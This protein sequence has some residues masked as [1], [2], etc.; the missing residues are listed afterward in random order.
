ML[1]NVPARGTCF[2]PGQPGAFLLHQDLSFRR[3]RWLRHTLLVAAGEPQGD[4]KGPYGFQWPVR[5]RLGH[6]EGSPG[7]PQGSPPPHSTAPALTM[8]RRG[9]P[10]VSKFWDKHS[11]RWNS[12]NEASWQ[13]GRV[14][15][16]YSTRSRHWGYSRGI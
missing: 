4:R 1:H 3:L 12:K 5:R 9:S 15:E 14:H 6:A 8:I 13:G 7:R 10:A 11:E 2:W 16:R